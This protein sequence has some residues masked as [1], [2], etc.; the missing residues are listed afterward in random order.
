MRNEHHAAERRTK[1]HPK[2]QLS[3]ATQRAGS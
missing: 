2:T 3:N 1:L